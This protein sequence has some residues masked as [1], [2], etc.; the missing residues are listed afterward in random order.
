MASS[1]LAGRG[2]HDHRV[3]EVMQSIPRHRFVSGKSKTEAYGDYPVSI[4]H[5]QTIS[6]PYMVAYMS[7]ALELQGT[8]KVLEIGTGSGYQTAILAELSGYVYS[9]ERIPEL[10]QR[11][12]T[13]LE[14]L[15]YSNIVLRVGDGSAGMPE[16]SPF[17]RILVTA[18]APG[19]AKQLK[20]QLA[21]NGIL[22]VPIGDYRSHQTLTI[23]RRKG[24][25][26]TSTQNMG[27]RFV[28]LVGKEGFR[29]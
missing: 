26:F 11:T 6:Q 15:G 18:A 12:A 27:C 10:S 5:G 23:V 29:L 22:V 7:Q 17:D 8:E 16:E 21:D 20:A 14:A 13:L 2:I 3:L 19:V 28:P 24:G 25:G 4:G 1:Q 9:V